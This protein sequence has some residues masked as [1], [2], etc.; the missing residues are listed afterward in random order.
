MMARLRDGEREKRQQAEGE[1]V[2]RADGTQVVRVRRRKRRTKQPEVEAR[3]RK[4]RSMKFVLPLV[5]AAVVLVGVAAILLV[6]KYNSR[7]FQDKFESSLEEFMGTR[8][9]I[10]RL[11][12]TPVKVRATS[13]RAEWPANSMLAG[14]ELTGLEGDLELAGFISGSWKGEEILATRG[15]MLLRS[16]SRL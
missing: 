7:G 5:I 8:L 16:G 10:E 3:K 2:T 6:A 14:L 11:R 9:T 15:T 4:K 1:L 12:V 13:V